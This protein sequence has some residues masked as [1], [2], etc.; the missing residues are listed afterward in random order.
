MNKEDLKITE[1]GFYPAME[2]CGIDADFYVLEFDTI[3]GGL[4]WGDCPVPESDFFWI[5]EKLKI[6]WSDKAQGEG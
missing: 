6:N 3:R 1:D 5:G 2:E 4:F